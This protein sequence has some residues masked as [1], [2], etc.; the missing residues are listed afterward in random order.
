MLKEPS[1][2]ILFQIFELG[3]FKTIVLI[4]GVK[5]TSNLNSVQWM[6][7]RIMA[8]YARACSCFSLTNGILPALAVRARIAST[9]SLRSQWLATLV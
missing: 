5:E 1:G 9:C 8:S 4:R 2:K 6:S 7:E 3:P